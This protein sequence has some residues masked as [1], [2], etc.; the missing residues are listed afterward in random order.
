[1]CL[2]VGSQLIFS[3]QQNIKVIKSSILN[4]TLYKKKQKKHGINNHIFVLFMETLNLLAN[5]L[6]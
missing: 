4:F 3:M 6:Q 5:H 2:C 1:M